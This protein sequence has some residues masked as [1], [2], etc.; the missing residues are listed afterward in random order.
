MKF[1][2]LFA[3]LAAVV[4][5][6]SVAGCASNNSSS[7]PAASQ[8]SS[9]YGTYMQAGIASVK[10]ADYDTAADK[11][12]QAYEAKKTAKAKAYENQADDFADAQ[13]DIADYE[14]KDAKHA[15]TSVIN[16]ESGYQLMTSR[17][18]R[19]RRKIQTVIDNFQ[20]DINPLRSQAKEEYANKQYSQAAATCE[21]ILNLSYINGKYYRRVRRQVTALQQRAQEAAEQAGQA[22]K[23]TSSQST[24]TGSYD[25][26]S[27]ANSSASDDTT[28]GGQAVSMSGRGQ[29]R[30]RLMDLGFDQSKFSDQQIIDLFRVAY[31]NGHQSPADITAADVNE[32][33]GR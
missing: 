20:E 15:L 19:L 22:A 14:F 5:S 26:S 4:M 25:G 3:V 8:Q 12:E 33:L 13:E 10:K 30:S 31:N 18:T 29:I 1:K 11:F 6:V 7:K 9:R 28:V 2:K 16:E 32:Y 21:R 17:A 24:T 23:S 27:S